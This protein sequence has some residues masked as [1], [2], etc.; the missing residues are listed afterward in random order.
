MIL[1]DIDWYHPCSKM[2]SYYYNGSSDH[3]GDTTIYFCTASAIL[4]YFFTRRIHFGFGNSKCLND[5][6]FQITKLWTSPRTA[7]T[8]YLSVAQ[9]DVK[10]VLGPCHP[11]PFQIFHTTRQAQ[12]SPF[13]FIILKLPWSPLQRI[14][15]SSLSA[16]LHTSDRNFY[17]PKW[18]KVA[19]RF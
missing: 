7:F 15:T 9:T 11:V 17:R 6:T 12:F 8:L 4:W 3:V 13:S 1:L 18:S 16:Y 10:Y 19:R 5:S 2:F 14:Y